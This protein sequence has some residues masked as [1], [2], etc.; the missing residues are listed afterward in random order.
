MIEFVQGDF[1]DFEA[2]IRVNT[3]NCVGVMGAGV[4]LLFKDRY[5]DMFLDYKRACERN[6]VKPGYPHVW[7]SVDLFDK[8]TIINLPTKIHWRNPS[9]YQ[10]IEDGL[11]WLEQYLKENDDAIVTLPAL[12]CGLGGLEWKKVRALIEKYLNHLECKILVF[13]PGGADLRNEFDPLDDELKGLDIHR[14]LPNDEH[15][16][17]NMRGKTATELYYKGNITLLHERIITILLNP[18]PTERELV[19]ICKILED[20]PLKSSVFVLG[21]NYRSEINLAREIISKGFKVILI[22]PYGIKNFKI[23]IAIE[24]IWDYSN[25]LIISSAEPNSKWSKY[26]GSKSFKL[27][28]RMSKI[29]IINS[30]DLENIEKYKDVITQANNMIFYINY[31]DDDLPIFKVLSARKIGLNIITRKP[32]I[33]SLLDAINDY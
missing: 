7:Q 17:F 31:W 22:I 32:N 8:F 13:E 23:P 3:V 12:G 24:S 2:S 14:I 25:I 9:E 5:P 26:E 21:Y 15:Y 16:P 33:S 11:I 6:E 19:S 20:L 27:R 4:A 29:M 1:F 10:Y 18:S 28:L 30:M